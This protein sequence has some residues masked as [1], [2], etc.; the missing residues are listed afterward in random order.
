MPTVSV[1]WESQAKQQPKCA[2]CVPAGH[3]MMGVHT[4]AGSIGQHS[5]SGK[6]HPPEDFGHS[7]MHFLEHFQDLLRCLLGILQTSMQTIASYEA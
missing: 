1:H 5:H 4:R 6:F 7:P 3:L 2:K